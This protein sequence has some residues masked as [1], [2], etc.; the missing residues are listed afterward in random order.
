MSDFPRVTPSPY[1][2][3]I[4]GV[5]ADPYRIGIAYGI[6]HPAHHHAIKKL[7]RAGKSHK[8]LE[9]DLRETIQSI[10]RMLAMMKEDS[11]PCAGQSVARAL[12]KQ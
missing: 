9:K 8:S 6:E 12:A 7:L 4:G 11:A 10:E 5:K 2:V 1:D 3:T